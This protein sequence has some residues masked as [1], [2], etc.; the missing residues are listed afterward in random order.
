MSFSSLPP[1]IVTSI[2]EFVSPN[3]IP[4]FSLT[5][6]WIHACGV[7]SLAKHQDLLS[8][9]SRIPIYFHT[10]SPDELIQ[11]FASDK[12]ASCYPQTLHLRAL[13]INDIVMSLLA[14]KRVQTRELIHGKIL[15]L[16]RTFSIDSTD[17]IIFIFFKLLPNLKRDCIETPIFTKVYSRADLETVA[18]LYKYK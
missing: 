5:S 4:A 2:W 15:Q 13:V 6:H 16:W 3:D 8:K 7:K 1:E 9:Y 11:L 10:Q 14:S 12:C 18:S 17:A